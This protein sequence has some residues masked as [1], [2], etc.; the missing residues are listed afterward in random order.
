[1][2]LVRQELLPADYEYVMVFRHGKL[3]TCL[4]SAPQF[5]GGK[6]TVFRIL[7][8]VLVFTRYFL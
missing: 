8:N 1:M 6:S 5:S 2:G 3:I 4:P 7:W